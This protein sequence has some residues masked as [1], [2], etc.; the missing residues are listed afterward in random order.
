[1]TLA[2]G[3]YV[4]LDELVRAFEQLRGD[5]DHARRAVAHLRCKG[6]F[7]L[8]RGRGEERGIEHKY[9]HLNASGQITSHHI[10]SHHITR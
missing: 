4:G 9:I 2:C 5:D 3:V 10:T 8:G 7:G 6:G 1:M